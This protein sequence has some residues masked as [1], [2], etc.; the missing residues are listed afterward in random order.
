MAHPLVLVVDD[1]EP[2]RQVTVEMV[3]DLGCEV[4]EATSGDQTLRLLNTLPRPP[5]LILLD[6]AMPNMNGLQLARA[7]RAHG[8]T[9]PI[10]LVTGYAELS[11]VEIASDELTGLLHKPFTIR[12]LR[13]MLQQ[14]EAVPITEPQHQQAEAVKC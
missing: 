6:Y 8:V 13:A 14:L 5:N 4:I 7:L 2:V 3:R 11:E 10:A 12:E 9:A 1:D